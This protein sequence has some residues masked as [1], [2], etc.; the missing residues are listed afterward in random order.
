MTEKCVKEGML[1]YVA[2]APP[3]RTSVRVGAIVGSTI[4]R[5]AN[6]N[7]GPLVPLRTPC[8]GQL[9]TEGLQRG[10]RGGLAAPRVEQLDHKARVLALQQR[11]SACCTR[12]ATGSPPSTES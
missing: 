11:A 9:S 3:A 10:G 12:R 2:S 5:A 7:G 1:A 6:R 8:A 4:A